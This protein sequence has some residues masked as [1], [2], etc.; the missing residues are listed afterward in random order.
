MKDWIRI[1]TA[2]ALVFID[3]LLTFV[4]WNYFAAKFGIAGV[5]YWEAMLLLVGVRAASPPHWL[6][7]KK[8]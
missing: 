4:V 1:P 8:G 2:V 6:P 5:T 7:P 3:A